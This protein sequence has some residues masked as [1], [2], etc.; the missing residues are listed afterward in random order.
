MR[1]GPAEDEA[2]GRGSAV[3][4]R[5]RDAVIWGLLGGISLL[6][7]ATPARVVFGYLY[8]APILLASSRPG[9][10]RALAFTLL[11]CA[12][13]LLNLVVPET[14]VDWP[15]RLVDR[16]L[17]CL[18]LAVTTGLSLRNRHLQERQMALEVR[19]ARTELRRDF[20]ATLAHDLKTPVMGTIATARML[21]ARADGGEL[22]LIR[23]GLTAILHSQERCLRLIEDLLQSFR[24]DTEGFRLER[25]PCDPEP[26]IRA[27]LGVVAPI[28]RERQIE[29]VLQGGEATGG[30]VLLGDR[31]HLQRLL[32]NLLLN[33]IAHSLRGGSVRIATTAETEAVRIAVTDDGPGFPPAALPRLFERFYQA[34]GEPRGS[35]LGLYLCR[36]IAEAHGGGIRA[37]NPAG[38][39]ACVE[40]R[41]PA[42]AAAAADGTGRAA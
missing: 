4:E 30:A 38:G 25:L 10:R 6:D 32:E 22:Q 29:L 28:A 26:L 11:C 2:A 9:R 33:G 14:A 3:R 31:Q 37:F 17:V 39:G 34:E 36:Q 12:L 41:L 8:V 15:V 24:A 23:R 7:L 40:V 42:A 16:L 5:T 35:G 20:L 1:G 19:L 21:T 13:T 18:A 27:A